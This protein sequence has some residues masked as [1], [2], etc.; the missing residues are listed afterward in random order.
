DGG[1]IGGLQ[2]GVAGPIV[3]TGYSLLVGSPF[4]PPPQLVSTAMA[5]AA[6]SEN[7]FFFYTYK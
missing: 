5:M 3:T 2:L 4:W 1:R 7:L 6:N